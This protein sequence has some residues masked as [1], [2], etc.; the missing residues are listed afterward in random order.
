VANGHVLQP[1][2]AHSRSQIRDAYLVDG[3]HLPVAL[4][5]LLQLPQEVPARA[6]EQPVGNPRRTTLSRL[7][8]CTKRCNEGIPE[9]AL[10]A[11]L[12]GGPELHAI[13]LGMLVAGRRQRATHH[14]ILMELHKREHGGIKRR[15]G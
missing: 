5:H 12:I 11:D 3:E 1:N 13:D 7:E 9:L 2:H 8:I 4:L 6:E 10:G 15:R 14:L